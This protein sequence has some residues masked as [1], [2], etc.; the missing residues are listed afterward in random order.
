MAWRWRSRCAPTLCGGLPACFRV[1]RRTHL[2]V[3][4]ATHRTTVPPLSRGHPARIIARH[5]V[6]RRGELDIVTALP[7]TAKGDRLGLPDLIMPVGL[8][9]EGMGNLMQ[10]RVVNRLVCS[11]LGIRVGEG[12]DSRLVVAAARALCGVVKLKTPALELVRRHPCGGARRNGLEVAVRALV[13]SRSRLCAAHLGGQTRIGHAIFA[14]IITDDMG[15]AGID[16][17]DGA[18]ELLGTDREAHPVARMKLGTSEVRAA[19]HV[20]PGRPQDPREQTVGHATFGAVVRHDVGKRASFPGHVP[21]DC[22]GPGRKGYTLTDLHLL[23]SREMSMCHQGLPRTRGITGAMGALR[24]RIQRRHAGGDALLIGTTPHLCP[25]RSV[26]GRH[27]R[28]RLP[29]TPTPRARGGRTHG[30]PTCLA[31]P[32]R[33]VVWY[34]RPPDPPEPGR[35]GAAGCRD[36]AAA[37][38]QISATSLRLASVSPSM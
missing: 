34:D 16:A 38:R 4:R 15:I 17:I 8:S 37:G 7:G 9:Y 11:R 10:E 24:Y 33:G 18:V 20:L 22:M 2:A 25:R 1:G 27:A 21:R 35:A 32:H 13:G 19:L 28:Q 23:P 12:D 26:A 36:A 30:L 5:D 6:A 31:R 29:A 14:G 3:T